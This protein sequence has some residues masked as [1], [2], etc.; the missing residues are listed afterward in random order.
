[1]WIQVFPQPTKWDRGRPPLSQ[2]E[3]DKRTAASQIKKP[4]RTRKP[5]KAYEVSEVMTIITIRGEKMNLNKSNLNN[6]FH[7][8]FK[9]K[10]WIFFEEIPN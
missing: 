1:M 6:L 3:R 2:E 9:K 5:K 7:H 10:Y 4:A 8:T